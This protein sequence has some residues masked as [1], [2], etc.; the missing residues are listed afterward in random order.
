M[1]TVLSPVASAN[2]RANLR[3]RV[4]KDMN[5]ILT[6]PLEASRMGMLVI[7][8]GHSRFYKSHPER[9]YPI[10]R[11]VAVVRIKMCDEAII[12]WAS[13]AMGG[14]HITFDKTA[15]AWYTEASGARAIV[16][17][18]RIRP[19]IIG[20]KTTLIDCMLSEGK[21]V[22]SQ[23]RPCVECESNATAMMRIANLKRR[24]LLP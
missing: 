14:T 8:E 23:V 19:F 2:E 12:R 4:L 20:E 9:L 16:V 15:G 11:W 13:D 3:R 22:R 17:L 24:G 5:S 6:D 10:P 7:T 21:Y 1:T 18:R